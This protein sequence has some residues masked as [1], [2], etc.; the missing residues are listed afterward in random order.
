M[1]KAQENG[2][3]KVSTLSKL[4]GTYELCF[5]TKDCFNFN[6]I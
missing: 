1:K 2:L 5:T 6:L 4:P 3:I